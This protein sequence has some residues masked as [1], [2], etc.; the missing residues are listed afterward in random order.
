M[1]VAVSSLLSKTIQFSPRTLSL[2]ISRVVWEERRR[3]I[4]G[5]PSALTDHRR[6]PGPNRRSSAGSAHFPVFWSTTVR[7]RGE[8]SSYQPI[9]EVKGVR[10][11]DGLRE[12]SLWTHIFW[13]GELG[14]GTRETRQA[15]HEKSAA[16]S[17][18]IYRA[19][20]T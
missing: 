17:S 3:G 10:L 15:A 13:S 2:M 12:P 1:D 11:K 4:P 20:N 14:E 19:R 16:T 6:S 5:P 18:V 8:V 9:F 7:G